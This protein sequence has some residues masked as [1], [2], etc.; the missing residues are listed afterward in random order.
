MATAGFRVP[1]MI[2]VPIFDRG[3]LSYT[4]YYLVAKLPNKEAWAWSLVFDVC[5]NPHELC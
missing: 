3:D 4:M 2:K 1:L 5:E